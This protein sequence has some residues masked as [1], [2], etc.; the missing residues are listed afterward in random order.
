MNTRADWNTL[1]HID[2]LTILR[3]TALDQIVADY[4]PADEDDRTFRSRIARETSLWQPQ[5]AEGAANEAGAPPNKEVVLGAWRDLDRSEAL[6]ELIDNSID[7]WNR[8]RTRYPDKSS[9]ELNIYIDIDS[10][11]GQLC[12][13]DNAGGVPVEKLENLVVPGHSE[14]DALAASIGSYKT[15]GKKAIFRL[16]TAVNVSTRFW[17]PAETGD[18]AVAVHLDEKWLTDVD[19]YKF[20]YF[21]LKDGGDMQRGQTRYLMQLRPEPVGAC[22]YQQPRELDKISHD[23]QN[24]Y[25]L[26][27]A[28]DGKINI[29]FPKRG[30]IIAN[31]LNS[32]YDFSGTTND[33][34]DIRPQ[35][36]EFET[37][38]DFQGRKHKVTIEVV[39]GCRVTTAAKDNVGPGFD[40][41][42]NNRLFKYR[43]ERLFYEQLPKS[44]AA[45]LARGWVNILGPNVFI[46]W[47]T[48]K[49][50][51]NYDREIIDLIRTHPAIKNLFEN[52]SE[53]FQQI[54]R[55]GSGEVTKTINVGHTLVNA[56]THALSFGDSSR[57]QIDA[58]KK[59]GQRLPE[60]IFRPHLATAK[61][62]KKDISISLNINFTIEEARRLAALFE[63]SG[64]LDAATTKRALSERAKEYL[65]DLLNAKRAK[66][67]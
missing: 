1:Q 8:R 23:I 5:Q 7:A 34:I 25:G 43:D 27:M 48:H 21:R 41:Y 47:D 17:N 3:E 54:S 51:L 13:E 64:S 19:L 26:L 22:W 59:R 67:A 28:R 57:V 16:A 66:R 62:T 12:Y 36:V 44:N 46:P 2:K 14:T 29:Y 55:L 10:D 65:L 56:A 24:T 32:R 58:T 11:T 6:L 4:K 49:R 61:K 20:P 52:W 33:K 37:E 53:A 45:N 40:L 30:K 35:R 50:H 9:P 15:G 18:T 42:G 60:G 39:I 63:I 31:A 38:L